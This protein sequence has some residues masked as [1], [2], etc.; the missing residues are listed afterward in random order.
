VQL[1]LPPSLSPAGNSSYLTAAYRHWR[2]AGG[3]YGTAGSVNPYVSWDS[4]Y[5]PAAALLLK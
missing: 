1:P 3:M 4:V 2:D 5:A